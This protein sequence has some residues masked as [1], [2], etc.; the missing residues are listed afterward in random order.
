MKYRKILS[1]VLL[2]LGLVIAAATVSIALLGQ[3]RA[4][5]ML[6]H[7]FRAK[8]AVEKMMT[9]VCNGDYADASSY[10][11]GRPDWGSI[12]D[13]SNLAVELIWIAFQDSMEYEFTGDCYVSDS[14]VSV[15]LVIRTMDVSAVIRG[16]EKH[17]KELL[18]RRLAAADA[19]ER[20]DT[21]QRFRQ[22][23]IDNVLRDAT[24]QSI[25]D[26]KELLEHKLTLDLLY[27]QGRW[28]ILPGEKLMHVLS[29]SF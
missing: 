20:Y 27:E 1:N 9:A 28:W 6:L 15:D 24:I 10:L 11:Y 7:P 13:N 26:N 2:F 21:D 17:A 22:E 23:M 25:E 18:G 4:P 14:G 16:L 5:K 3:N 12:P 19:A 29:G 8:Q